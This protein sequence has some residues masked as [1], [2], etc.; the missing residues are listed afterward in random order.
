[1]TPLVWQ[2]HRTW[3]AGPNEVAEVNLARGQRSKKQREEEQEG[4]GAPDRTARIKK[5][6]TNQAGSSTPVS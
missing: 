2:H 6:R 1:M 3:T 5:V 4:I